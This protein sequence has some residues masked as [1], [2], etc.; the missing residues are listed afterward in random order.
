LR[1]RRVLQAPSLHPHFLNAP[2]A[3]SRLERLSQAL[4]VVD[5]IERRGR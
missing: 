5:L 4:S 3:A 2:Q 1:R